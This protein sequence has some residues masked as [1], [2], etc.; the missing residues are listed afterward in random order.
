MEFIAQNESRIY[1]S[2]TIESPGDFA[3][4]FHGEVFPCLLWDHRGRFTDAE[5]AELAGRLLDAGCRY[6][7]CGGAGCE[8]WHDA[9]DM[10]CVTRHLDDSE[11][12]RES[13][14]IMTTWH[15][16][17]TPDEVALFF[18]TCTNF[19]QHHFRR[20]L[21]VHVGSGKQ[22]NEVDTAVRRYALGEH[23]V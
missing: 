4:P 14:H 12:V 19:G 9:I 7:V 20:F 17:E 23:A 11:E 22:R 13:M 10:E 6:A 2:L 8:A 1:G 3:T 21:V 16:G 5:Q 18:V 15:D